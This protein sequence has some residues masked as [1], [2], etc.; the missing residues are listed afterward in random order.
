MSTDIS[1]GLPPRGLMAHAR[2]D[3]LPAMR[4]KGVTAL[5][6]PMAFERWSKQHSDL[7]PAAMGAHGVHSVNIFGAIGYD[8]WTGVENTVAT[9]QRDLDEAAGKPVDVLINSPGGDMFEGI[10]IYNLLRQYP[11]R[12]TVKIIGLAASAASIIAM[13]GDEIL[14]ADSG[15]LMIHNC[16]VVASGNRHDLGRLA[17]QM[18]PFDASLASVYATRTGMDKAEIAAM[19]DAESF[20]NSEDAIKMGFADGV[21]ESNAVRRDE[22]AGASAR[23]SKALYAAEYGMAVAGMSRAERRQNMQSLIRMPGA[24]DEGAMP[25]AGQNSNMPS[26]V[27]TELADQAAKL[28][29]LLQS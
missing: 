14:L 11:A 28:I 7:R 8:W 2:P 17:E 25:G 22:S 19:M 20:I 18:G 29:N 16:W 13:T 24:A 23:Q 27:A 6:K 3:A 10:G 1:L 21:L 4:L 15:F 12:V 9:V 26:A 5:T